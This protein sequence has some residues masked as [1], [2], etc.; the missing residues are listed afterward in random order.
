MSTGNNTKAT[1]PDVPTPDV[2]AA[3]PVI[4]TDK[5]NGRKDGIQSSKA[6]SRLGVP[7]DDN[8]VLKAVAKKR[9]VAIHEVVAPVLAKW[10]ED[11]R[12]ALVAE[13]DEFLK[14]T[15]KSPEELEKELAKLRAAQARL[16]AMLNGKK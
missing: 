1:T 16:E 5:K 9:D 4:S 14:T 6:K 11:N 15:E 13:A 3:A 2:T 10:F 8:N 7:A 12:A